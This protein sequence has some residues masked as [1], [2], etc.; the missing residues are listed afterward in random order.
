MWTV[1]ARRDSNSDHCAPVKL[2][3]LDRRVDYRVARFG[4]EG[5][6]ALFGVLANLDASDLARITDSKRSTPPSVL[7]KATTVR[8]AVSNSASDRLNSSCWHSPWA[9]SC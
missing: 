7:A 8:A 1:L 9:M 3:E 5:S 6:D 4:D 2:D